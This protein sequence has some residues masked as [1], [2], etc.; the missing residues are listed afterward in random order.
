MSWRKRTANLLFILLACTFLRTNS[1]FVLRAQNPLPAAPKPPFPKNLATPRATLETFSFAWEAMKEHVGEAMPVAQS[2]LDFPPGIGAEE[3][4]QLVIFLGEVLDLLSPP[5]VSVSAAEQPESATLVRIG[6]D[7]AITLERGKDRLWRFDRSTIAQLTA[8][9]RKVIA[10]NKS[11]ED[12]RRKFEEGLGDATQLFETFLG[13]ALSGNWE[14]AARC[15]DLRELAPEVRRSEGPRLAALLASSMQRIG[16]LYFQDIPIDPTRPA[17]AWWSS[18]EG[19][20]VCSK[21]VDENAPPRWAFNTGTVRRIESLWQKMKD[22][23]PDIRWRILNKVL[24]DPASFAAGPKL[25]PAVTAEY[26]SPKKMMET[27]LRAIDQAEHDDAFVS[28]CASYLD[29][30]NF[31]EE[32]AARI[33]PKY[34]EKLEI[35]LRKLKPSIQELDDRWTAPTTTLADKGIKVRLVR[36][37]DGRWGFSEDTVLRIPTMFESLTPQEKGFGEMNSGRSS[38]RETFITFLRAVNDGRYKEAAECL[39][40]SDLPI[41]AR[42]QM[43]PLLALKLKAVIDRIGWVY[44]HEIPS[45]AQGPRYLWHRGPI[46]R[47]SISRSADQVDAGWRF[48]DSTVAGLD[49]AM[50]RMADVPVD[51]TLTSRPFIE[52]LPSWWAAPG[53]RIRFLLPGGLKV[54]LGPLQLWQWLGLLFLPALLWLGFVVLGSILDPLI[55]WQLGFHGREERPK[56]HGCLRSIRFLIVVGAGIFLIPWLDL[57]MAV[58]AIIYTLDDFFVTAMIIWSGFG[59]VDLVLLWCN[60]HRDQK[61]I[62]GFQDLLLPFLARIVKVMLVVGALIFIVSCFDEGTLLA[63]FL[64]GLG[65]VGLAVSLAAQ[66]SLKNL[67]A[68]M[69]LI[70][71]RSFSVGD[72]IHTG[73]HEGTVES[74][75]FRSTRLKTKEDSILIVPNSNLAGSTIDNLGVRAFRR[76]QGQIYLDTDNAPQ[77]LLQL[78]NDVQKWL[79]ERDDLD[80]NRGEAMIQGIAEMGLELRYTAYVKGKEAQANQF[81]EAITLAMLDMCQKLGLKVA[82]LSTPS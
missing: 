69:L 80:P 30:A 2:C 3:K 61:Q 23:P 17:Y 29:L 31:T 21:V 52:T 77:S 70:G 20:I 13:S 47:I 10:Q 14:T 79:K 59:V 62:Q 43:G 25:P 65:V 12:E 36:R 41:S 60:K 75:G 27:F 56:I 66:D 39:D 37:A 4:G 22:R 74:V 57:P 54:K 5:F 76:I 28:K 9:Y 19:A 40:L 45:D 82:P 1:N 6:P 8:T 7:A 18:T 33:G 42:S 78:R 53:L 50:E 68:T 72:L 35:I 48:T 67:F 15:L 64:A 11:Y 24:P 34:A 63:R 44:F 38:P 55:A 46:G 58:G 32:E 71:D 26:S 51:P 49:Q 73:S 81:R 16:F